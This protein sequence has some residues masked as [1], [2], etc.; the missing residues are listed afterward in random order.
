VVDIA[1]HLASAPFLLM[2]H[3]IGP[4]DD[5]PFH[6][7]V[8]PQRF[9]EQMRLLDRLGIRG[10]SVREL[11]ETPARDAPAARVGLTFDD[12]YQDFVTEALPILSRHGFTATVF[13]VAGR[14]GQSNIWDR[15]GPQKA[16]MTAEHVRM[17]ANAGMEVG[18]HSLRHT[19][20]PALGD[21]ALL[22]EVEQS[23]AVL[24]NVTGQQVNGFCYPYG[25][26]TRREAAAVRNAG[27]EYGCAVRRSDLTGRYALPRTFIGDRDGAARMFAKW[28]RHLLAR[29][30]SQR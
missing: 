23:R 5:D 15:P 1:L 24:Q 30:A 8:R 16:L 19:P 29:R 7:T 14:L 13:V 22:A 28:V 20:L 12:G 26:L 3:S 6:I 2:Y 18:S 17:A 10:A 21:D 27:Y 25:D 4:V 11:L 9:E